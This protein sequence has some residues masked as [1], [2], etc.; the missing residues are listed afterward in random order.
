M[1]KK[2]MVKPLRGVCTYLLYSLFFSRLVFAQANPFYFS[3]DCPE[4][5]PDNKNF[6]VSITARFDNKFSEVNIY[7]F[8]ENNISIEGVILRT[9]NYEKK[10][11][12]RKA[13][14]DDEGRKAYKIKLPL[15]DSQF[16]V[17]NLFQL[18][19]QINPNYN[20]NGEINFAVETKSLK[21]NSK[22]AA[23]YYEQNLPD[24]KFETYIPQQISGK[25]LLLKE[26]SKFSFVV[27]D[28]NKIK[29]L[30]LEF[31]AK[32]D[33]PAPNFFSIVDLKSIDTILSLSSNKFYV[34][35]VKDVPD[36]KIYRQTFIGKNTWTHFTIRLS[37]QNKLAEVWANDSLVFTYSIKRAFSVND[38][39]FCL[40]GTPLG[41]YRIDLLKMW[42]FNNSIDLSFYNKNYLNYSADSSRILLS[43][44]FD[45]GNQLNE[46]TRN[47]NLSSVDFSDLTLQNS[48][49]PIFS[50]A[51]E[52]NLTSF[53]NFYLLEWRSKDIKS[54]RS[55]VLEKSLQGN[56]FEEIYRTDAEN[57]LSRVY[58]YTDEKNPEH[59]VVSYR[60]KQLNKD[61]TATYSSLIKI[62]QGEKKPF[63]IEQ[64]FPNPFNP[65]TNIVIQIVEP[66]D[67]KIS[68]YDLVGKKIAQLYSGYLQKGKYEFSFD[69]TQFPS[70]I[71]FYEVQTPKFQEVRKMILAK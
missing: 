26:N 21:N 42:D 58:S 31:W 2:S 69:G 45:S 32:F 61:G 16:K 52:L 53:D 68:V 14:M 4:F 8:F 3:V 47:P 36:L 50:R 33:S 15:D 64:N 27:N 24:V 56:N 59:D 71:Y 62:G 12:A 51:P 25:S 18:D 60:I 22:V 55:Y 5:I 57:D 1:F 19:L 35:S 54:A 43:L 7:L 40:D 67:V 34:A 13:G 66:T 28:K 44:N 41:N 38:L 65:I 49:A 23:S 30:L 9:N 48:D 20:Y 37:K 46:L 10:L 29:N 70:G 39:I 63:V 11:K 17:S 6:D